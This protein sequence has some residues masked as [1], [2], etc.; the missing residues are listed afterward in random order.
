MAAPAAVAGKRKR[1][2]SEDEV[3]LLLHRYAPSTILTA[4]QEVA[5]HADGRRI[6]WR[7]V[8]GKSTTGITSAR[9][10]Q[11]LWRHVAYHH[12]LD[13][14]VTGGDQPLGDDSDL[15]LEL[16]P[17]PNPT[18]EDLSEATALAKALIS[19]SSRDQASGHRNLDAP[20]LNTLNEKMVRVPSEKQLGQSHR[21]INNTGPVSN[22]KQAS[23][24][25]PSPHPLDANGAS[26]KKKKTKAWSKEEDA[27]LTAG[28]QKYGEGNWED[29]LQ[30][31]NFDN[32]RTPDLL[33]QRWALICKRPGGSTKHASS[34]HGTVASSE[35]RKA[36]LNALKMAVGPIRGTSALRSG[37]HQQTIQHKSTVFAP[38]IPEVRSGAAPSPAPAPPPA[39]ALPVPV[40]DS[41]PSVRPVSG[42]VQ[43][44]SPLHQGQ[45]A[46]ARAAPPKQSNASNKTRK[47]QAAKPNPAIIQSSIQ[48]AAFAAGGR[49]APASAAASFLKAAQSKTAVHI[50]HQGAGPSQSSASYKASIMV[51]DPGTQPGVSLHAE[52]PNAT[53][54]KSGPSVLTMHAT[55]QVHGV[56]E[57]TAANQPGPLVGAHLMDT[58]K[59]FSTTPVPVS[60]E[61]EEVDDDSKFEVT[62][63]DLFPEDAKQL[64]TLDTKAKQLET[65]DMKAKQPET[66]NAKAKQLETVDAK[67]KQPETADGL[68]D[69][70]DKDMLEFDQ[71][72]ASQGHLNMDHLNKGKS[73]KS[74]SQ[75][76]GLVGSQKK[77]LKPVA[78]AVGKD[79]P[80]SAGMLATGK[81]AKTPAPHFVAGSP[82]GIVGTVTA[83]PPNKTLA[84]KAPAPLP[85]QAPLQKKHAV[86]AKG[87]QMVSGNA[88][89]LNSG[90]ATSGQASVAANG[91]G[92]ANPRSSS[93]HASTVV[94]LG[95]KANTPSSIHSGAAVNGANRASSSQASA[96]AVSGAANPPPSSQASADGNGAANKVNPPPAAARQ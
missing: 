71:F 36:A 31:Y 16:E 21:I 12:D 56:S 82:R 34:K 73:A 32:T 88:A 10:Y 78:A 30:K 55:E 85:S 93:V 42:S 59:A 92:K 48:A 18:T 77:P 95:N 67:A 2:L 70:K 44:Q 83:N 20:M 90:V 76:Q 3:Y 62:L 15:E 7:A 51:V 37:V 65:L 23:H 79:N 69:P 96:V 28:V 1:S 40:P 8:V 74:A 47:K 50:R 33:S 46:P 6:D 80:V 49:L 81:K 5:Q 25:G 29:I 87:N 72:V 43:V 58:K 89:T 19:G 53:A 60:R 75:A 86:S 66:V 14:S 57:I 9:E 94:S 63:D 35:E 64:E 45:Q 61:S 24:S 39:L 17:V 68:V 84:R 52:P 13:E 26:K 41:V 22:S 4:L 91:A 11:M 27:D 54:P 38:N